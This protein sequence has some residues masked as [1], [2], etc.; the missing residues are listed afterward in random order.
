[1]I[2]MISFYLFACICPLSLHPLCMSSRDGS[3][4]PSNVIRIT[5]SIDR[6]RHTTGFSN[7]QQQQKKNFWPGTTK[8]LTKKE[9]KK[10]NEFHSIASMAEQIII[11][12]PKR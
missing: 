5:K 11:K 7:Q 4:D 9:K 1:M 2:I 8:N 12:I 6:K 10:K 3:I